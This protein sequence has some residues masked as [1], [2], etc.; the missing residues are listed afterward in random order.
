MGIYYEPMF[1]GVLVI[2]LGL[3]RSFCRTESCFLL[4]D[5]SPAWLRLK[6]LWAHR[7]NAPEK[8]PQVNAWLFMG[9]HLHLVA[10]AKEQEHFGCLHLQ[11]QKKRPHSLGYK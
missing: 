8:V 11:L 3:G 7:H 4:L 2:L 5:L 9:N 10:S 6:P 1:C